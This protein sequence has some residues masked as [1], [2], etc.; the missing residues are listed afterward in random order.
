MSDGTSVYI[1]VWLSYEL[2]CTRSFIIFHCNSHVLSV[3]PPYV[4]DSPNSARGF[5]IPN[6]Q[7][8]SLHCDMM[9]T[10]SLLHYLHRWLWQNKH[11]ILLKQCALCFVRFSQEATIIPLNNINWMVLV[12]VM[13]RFFR[14]V[15]IAIGIN[16]RLQRDDPW[17]Q[18][19]LAFNKSLHRIQGNLNIWSCLL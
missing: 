16:P 8:A 19:G 11:C 7:T 18:V 12:K 4:A 10:G 2:G 6:T 17:Q 13:V 1:L 15:A 5:N 9:Q 14:N 3:W